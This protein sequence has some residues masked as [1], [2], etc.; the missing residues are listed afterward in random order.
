MMN[1]RLEMDLMR[2][3]HGELPE[4]RAR[5]LRER[6]AREP[7]LA[8]G[9][10][11]LEAVWGRLDLPPA[12][13]PPLGFAGRVIARAR[14]AQ[15]GK[16]SWALAPTWVRTTAAAA[17]AAGLA[18][19]VGIGTLPFGQGGTGGG[20]AAPAVGVPSVPASG[21]SATGTG[22]SA[23]QTGPSASGTGPVTGT[24]PSGTGS[25]PSGSSAGEAGPSS[26]ASPGSEFEPDAIAG[27]DLEEGPEASLAA[28]YWDDVAGVG[29]AAG[30]DE[31]A[32]PTEPEAGEALP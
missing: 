1:R 22:E 20:Q 5:E 2:L 28:S 7:E 8:D 32:E 10:R 6:L 19:G 12:A 24:G 14:E 15:A 9:Y 25:G 18:V 16:I 26:A 17:L 21:P 31:G 30:E 27:L 23:T 29:E 13:P 11:R 4:P 3:L